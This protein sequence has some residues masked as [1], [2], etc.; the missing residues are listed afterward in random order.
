MRK[1]RAAGWIH[2][3]QRGGALLAQVHESDIGQFA[4]VM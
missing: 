3:N 4:D 2:R 1:P